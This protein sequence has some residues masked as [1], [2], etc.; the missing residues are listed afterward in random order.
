MIKISN[1]NQSGHLK[2]AVSLSPKENESIISDNFPISTSNKTKELKSDSLESVNST[3]GLK[4]NIR[5]GSSK[6]I[7]SIE[8]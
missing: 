2:K 5:Q 3:L 1:E 4:D 8:S 6:S 7:K